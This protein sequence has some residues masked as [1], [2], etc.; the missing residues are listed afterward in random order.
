MHASQYGDLIMMRQLL[1][2]GGDLSAQRFD[3]TP[4]MFA[5]GLNDPAAAAPLVEGAADVNARDAA[6]R[7][8]LINAVL[9]A[10][11]R[12]P[13]VQALMRAGADI[14]VRDNEG[15][16]ALALAVKKRNTTIVQLLKKAGWS[17]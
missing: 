17:E 7:S 2:K 13:I 14:N 5:V 10:T 3:Q 1:A 6:G 11:D 12:V 4:P 8:V 15:Q 16:T 9:A